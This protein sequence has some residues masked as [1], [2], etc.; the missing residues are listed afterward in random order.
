MHHK[1][2]NVMT[3]NGY[4]DVRL[5]QRRGAKL[6]GQRSPATTREVAGEPASGTH[7]KPR[8]EDVVNIVNIDRRNA[9]DFVLYK[10]MTPEPKWYAACRWCFSFTTVSSYTQPVNSV[11]LKVLLNVDRWELGKPDEPRHCF[12][13]IRTVR[14]GEG[15][16]GKGRQ[17]KQMQSRN[18]IDRMEPNCDKFIHRESGPTSGGSW[19]WKRPLT[20]LAAGD[21]RQRGNPLNGAVDM[22][23]HVG[24]SIGWRHRGIGHTL[25]VIVTNGRSG[26]AV[27]RC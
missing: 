2:V 16:A 1:P 7:G 21:V 20:I 24:Y 22:L 4:R 11:S 27:T 3:V 25:K 9:G 17:R 6:P 13:G 14:N 10:R 15:S 12:G 8:G 23:W 18:R 19:R 26:C 5:W